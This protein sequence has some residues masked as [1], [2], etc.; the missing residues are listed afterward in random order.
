MPESTR[1][2]SRVVTSLLLL[3][4]IAVTIGGG[5]LQAGG[6]SSLD[7]LARSG[8]VFAIP[9]AALLL[10]AVATVGDNRRAFGLVRP[11]SWRPAL[12]PALVVAVMLALAVASGLP[13]AETLTTLAVNAAFVGLSEELA[14]RGLLLA[15]LL[16]YLPV[17]RAVLLSALIF[18]ATHSLNALMTGELGAAIAQ[19]ALAVGMGLWAARLRLETGSL[20]APIAL[21]ALWDLAL[22]DVIAGGATGLL[23][24]AASVVALLGAALLGVWGWRRLPS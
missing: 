15:T 4:W 12:T 2:P 14:F 21:H 9:A 24:V 5:L 22:L 16:A 7:A 23:P 10:L 19:S 20:V 3:A 13:T 8:I 1:R 18:G 6:T 11:S 17:R